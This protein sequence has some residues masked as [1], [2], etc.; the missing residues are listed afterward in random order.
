MRP[1]PDYPVI[2]WKRLPALLSFLFLIWPFFQGMNRYFY[3]TYKPDAL[4]QPYSLYLSIDGILFTI[5]AALF[6]CDVASPTTREMETL[7]SLC[8]L[9]IGY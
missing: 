1:K 5:E 7:L 2:L 9:A 3:A 4:P 6:F 8:F